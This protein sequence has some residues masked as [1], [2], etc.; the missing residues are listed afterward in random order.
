MEVQVAYEKI[1]EKY[2]D[3]KSWFA[4]KLEKLKGTSIENS[5]IKQEQGT[6]EELLEKSLIKNQFETKTK[7]KLA[8]YAKT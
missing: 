7:S 8:L 4:D 1:S 3:L 5:P 2:P 6:N